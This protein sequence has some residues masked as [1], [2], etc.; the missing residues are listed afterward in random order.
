[1]QMQSDPMPPSLTLFFIVEPPS[2][3]YLACYL[4]ASIR[5]HFPPEVRLVGYCPE[6]R[7]SEV[8]PAAV[9][10]LR[11]MNC[12]VR[13]FKAEGMFDP[14]YPHGNKIL[15]CLQ[16]RETEFSGFV[17]SDVVMTRANTV[18][19]LVRAGHVSASPAASLRWAPPDLW[20]RLYGAFEMPVPDERIRLMRDRRVAVVPYYSSG[21][22][23]FPEQH[24]TTEGQSFPQVW[25]DTARHIDALPNLDSKRPYLDQMTLPIAIRRAGL[26]WNELTENQHYILGG[27]RRGKA[28]ANVDQIF[29]VHYRKWEVLAEAGMAQ[30]AYE[31]LREQVGTSRVKW[32]YRAPLP[33]GI[34]PMAEAAPAPSAPVAAT[35]AEAPAPDTPTPDTPSGPDPSKARMAAVTMVKGDHAFLARWIGY[36]GPLIGRENLYILRHGPDPEIDR[37]AEGANVVHLPDT[38]DKS[39]FDRRR[40]ATLSQFTGG[41]TLYYNWVLCTDV[42]EI[43]APDPATGQTLPDYLDALF[44]TG[45]APRVISPFAIEIVHTPATEPEPLD[46][47]RPILS[48][49]RNFRLNS[50]YAKPCITRGRIAFSIGGHGST[51]RD[52]ALDPKLFLFHLRFMDDALSRARL[53]SR[54]A[55]AEEKSGPPVET[56]KGGSTWHQGT[57]SFEILSKLTPVEE[58]AE[59][60]D[61][62]QKMRE[63][64]TQAT[65]GNWFFR[66]MRSAE[67]Y[68]LPDRFSTLF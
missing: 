61:F 15:A 12:E 65:S 64:R 32:I 38:G 63:G 35:T 47:D 39:G 21:F 66:G 36:Y 7:L 2:Y 13:G 31:G 68:R 57:E 26:A 59:F 28:V 46:P 50:N 37:I 1:M 53:L 56:A 33:A 43:V 45:R 49:R 58:R 19:S 24:R 42:D 29:A 23:L 44:A 9:E 52:V 25:Y 34:A 18:E 3:Q 54:K 11:R 51:T 16:P 55:W 60:P 62:V 8:D 17:D 27:S 48:V 41:L 30:A 4:A 6:H 20:E 5:K 67:L 40:W 14:V 22:V 10:T